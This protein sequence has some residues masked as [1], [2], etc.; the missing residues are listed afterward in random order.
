MKTLI[1]LILSILMPNFGIA[2]II[3]NT[4]RDSENENKILTRKEIEGLYFT[5]MLILLIPFIIL[6]AFIILRFEILATW[7]SYSIFGII[8]SAIFMFTTKDLK[9]IGVGNE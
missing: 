2:L 8:I 1:K 4:V 5:S 3:R 7:S 6:I 9:V